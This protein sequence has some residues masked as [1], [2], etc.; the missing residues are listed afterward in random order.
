[1]CNGLGLHDGTGQVIKRCEPNCVW[2]ER[3]ECVWY[4]SGRCGVLQKSLIPEYFS[5]SIA[6]TKT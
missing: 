3:G 6:N 1:M 5:Q 4:E 2:C